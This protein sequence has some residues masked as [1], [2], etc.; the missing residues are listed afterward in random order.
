MRRG[1]RVDLLWVEDD[2][3]DREL[4][5]RVLRETAPALHICT[6]SDGREALA[7]L[8]PQNAS[9]PRAVLLDLNLPDMSGIEVLR[10][11]RGQPHTRTLPVVVFTGSANPHDIAAC[12][13]AGANSYV[14]KPAEFGDYQ[15]VFFQVATYW[16]RHNQGSWPF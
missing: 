2:L 5:L 11:I 9:L 7:W 8:E 13:R 14:V 12:Y 15:K 1:E 3:T 16:V 6:A 10:H 4:I